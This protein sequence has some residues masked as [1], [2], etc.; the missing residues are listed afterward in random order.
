[1][2]R[3]IDRAEGKKARKV[4]SSGDFNGDRFYKSCWQDVEPEALKLGDVLVVTISLEDNW[5]S[6]RKHSTLFVAFSRGTL[7]L[8]TKK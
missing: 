6:A 1:V 7:K 3:S 8:G 5:I 4:L 2:L